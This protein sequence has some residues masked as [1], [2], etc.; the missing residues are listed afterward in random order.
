MYMAPEMLESAIDDFNTQ[1]FLAVDVYAMG[2]VLWEMVSR[3]IALTGET[4]CEHS[5]FRMY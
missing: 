5:Y 3:C 4:Y 2:L 1:N